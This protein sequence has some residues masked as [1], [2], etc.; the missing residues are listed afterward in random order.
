MGRDEMKQHA[1]WTFA[2]DVHLAYAW[3]RMLLHI[4]TLYRHLVFSATTSRIAQAESSM[5]Q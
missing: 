5:E 1:S 4:T 2:L 3:R